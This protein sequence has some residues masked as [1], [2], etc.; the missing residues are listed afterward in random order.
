ML[1]WEEMARKAAAAYNTLDEDEKKGTLIF[2]NNYGLAGALNYY[3]K[4]YGLPEP[5][6]DNASFLYW[7]P[8]NKPIDNLILITDNE[9][10]LHESYIKDFLSARFTDSVTSEYARERGDKIMLA[11]CG[12]TFCTVIQEKIKEDK[13][14]LMK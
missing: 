13:E 9:D 10:E 6:S 14:A 1:G 4:K 8:D 2:C 3:G 11:K 12:C 5:Y 7:L